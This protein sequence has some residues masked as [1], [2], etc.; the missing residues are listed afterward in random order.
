MKHI[1]IVDDDPVATLILKKNLELIQVNQETITFSNGKEAYEFFKKN[2]SEKE[3][4][5]IFLDINM[6]LMNGWDFLNNINPF[7]NKVNTHIYI[8]TSSINKIDMDIATQYALIEKY[9]SKPINKEVL[10]AIKEKNKW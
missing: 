8:L 1:L 10:K 3:D 7:I 5:Y 9:L 4:Y 2:Y 6:P